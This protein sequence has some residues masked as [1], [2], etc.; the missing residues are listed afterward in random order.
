[1]VP[2]PS[3][4]QR[5]R[6]VVP[7]SKYVGVQRGVGQQVCPLEAPHCL[8]VAGCLELFTID[9]EEALVH[10]QLEVLLLAQREHPGVQRYAALKSPVLNIRN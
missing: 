2:C 4:W 5:M 10:L 7:Y 8:Q 1:M 6:P 3:T 9:E